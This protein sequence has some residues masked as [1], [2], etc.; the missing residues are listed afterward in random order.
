[1]LIPKENKIRDKVHL[2]RVRGL[3][4]FICG[5]WGCDAHHLLRAQKRGMGLKTGDD[6]ALPLCHTHHSALH[7]AGDEIKYFEDL[8]LIYNDVV[9]FTQ[10]LYKKTL[11][12]R[13]TI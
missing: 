4:C 1:M 8:G 6:C 3:P 9:E 2:K 10:N 12:T 5:G 13:K 11:Q 7:R